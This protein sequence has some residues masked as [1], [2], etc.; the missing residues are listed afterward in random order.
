MQKTFT[1]FQQKMIYIPH[2][3]LNYCTSWRKKK[4]GSARK[5]LSSFKH[6]F[7]K[8]TSWEIVCAIQSTGYHSSKPCMA[9]CQVTYRT[10]YLWGYLLFPQVQQG[11]CNPDPCIE[12]SHIAES[13]R[14][15]SSVSTSAVRNTTPFLKTETALT[16]LSFQKAVE[17][18]LFSQ[19]LYW[20]FI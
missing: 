14:E 17:T 3:C 19:L 11:E 6:R 4:R 2:F 12:Q 9:Q 10:A 15:P 18:W 1:V 16:F 20:D 8:Q 5:L 13:R 7:V